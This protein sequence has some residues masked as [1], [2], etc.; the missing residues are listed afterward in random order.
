MYKVLE[1]HMYQVG[2]VIA[3]CRAPIVT[4]EDLERYNREHK[5]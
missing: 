5:Q 2:Y 4:L 3:A 1:N